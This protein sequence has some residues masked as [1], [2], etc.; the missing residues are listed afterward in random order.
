MLTELARIHGVFHVS[1]LR[2]YLPNL[3]HVLQA[4][5]VEIKEDLSYEEEAVQIF[6]RKE[7][8]FEKQDD[9]THENSLET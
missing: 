9:H 5:S 7:A 4:Q 3:S 2:K 1:R 6:N 8:G